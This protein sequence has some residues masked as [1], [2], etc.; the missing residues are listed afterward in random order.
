MANITI[1][2]II[3]MFVY[4]TV[5]NFLF[6]SDS[7]AAGIFLGSSIHETAQVAGAGMIYHTKTMRQLSGSCYITKLIR[8]TAMIIIIPILA[9][10]FRSDEGLSSNLSRMKSIFPIS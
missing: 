10:Q 1:F 4:P 7:V 3:A 6:R 8:N 5:A 2:G 9:Y